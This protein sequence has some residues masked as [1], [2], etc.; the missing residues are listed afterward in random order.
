MGTPFEKFR[1]DI[2]ASASVRCQ[3]CQ[4]RVRA[5]KDSDSG[6]RCPKCG[7]DWERNRKP[8]ATDEDGN[9]IKVIE[10]GGK[11]AG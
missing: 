8:L 3:V 10:L 9:L 11:D 2:Q 4:S 5:C 7:R 6:L 1:Q